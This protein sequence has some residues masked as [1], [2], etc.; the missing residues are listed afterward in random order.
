[1]QTKKTFAQSRAEFIRN[2]KKF[3]SHSH[4]FPLDGLKLQEN[5]VWVATTADM[6][7][8]NELA[9]EIDWLDVTGMGQSAERQARYAEYTRLHD[10]LVASGNYTFDDNTGFW[11]EDLL[12]TAKW[13]ASPYTWTPT[14]VSEPEKPKS[15]FHICEFIDVG[16]QFSKFVCK[17]C[18]TE[19]K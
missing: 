12:A 13:D 4:K 18:G 2:S 1:M 8:A 5:G 15:D 10:D 19:R 9:A 14:P 3:V 16:F 7:R 17:V 11:A 6:D